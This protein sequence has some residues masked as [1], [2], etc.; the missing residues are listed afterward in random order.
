[1]WRTTENEWEQGKQGQSSKDELGANSKK[2]RTQTATEKCTIL[3]GWSEN[4]YTFI[5]QRYY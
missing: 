1:M 5:E 2:T 4:C 3:S